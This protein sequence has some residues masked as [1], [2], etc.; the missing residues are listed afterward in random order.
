MK[1][2]RINTGDAIYAFKYIV[3]SLAWLSATISAVANTY[4]TPKSIASRVSL[5][6][7]FPFLEDMLLKMKPMMK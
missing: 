2:S 6:A 1:R 4:R 3:A 5:P 7:S